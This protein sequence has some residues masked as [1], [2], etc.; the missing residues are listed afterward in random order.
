MKST[1]LEMGLRTFL[2][3]FI[4][5]KLKRRR[6]RSGSCQVRNG[7]SVFMEHCAFWRFYTAFLKANTF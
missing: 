2:H 5:E 6:K 4:V 3:Y 1:L 7:H